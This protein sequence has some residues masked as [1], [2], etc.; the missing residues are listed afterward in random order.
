[1][2]SDKYYQLMLYVEEHPLAKRASQGKSGSGSIAR[3]QRRLP[4][5]EDAIA[6][7]TRSGERDIDAPLPQSS[8]SGAA[9]GRAKSKKKK[10]SKKTTVQEVDENDGDGSLSSLSGS[11][12]SG[13][14]IRSVN[15]FAGFGKG[16]GTVGMSGVGM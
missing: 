14:S 16:A 2:Y 8:S 5:R 1:M 4:V 12:D 6:A 11:S 10:K 9:A 13:E 15:D 3:S 7:S